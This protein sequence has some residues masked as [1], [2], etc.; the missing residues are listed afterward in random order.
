MTSDPCR[1][2]RSKGDVSTVHQ[3]LVDVLAYL[4]AASVSP[5]PRESDV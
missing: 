4:A 1:L 2:T 5:A 3:G